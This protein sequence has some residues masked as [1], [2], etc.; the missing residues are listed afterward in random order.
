MGAAEGGDRG[1]GVVVD[2][3][4]VGVGCGART[5]GGGG[6]SGVDGVQHRVGEGVWSASSGGG[7]GG[8]FDGPVVRADAA[9]GVGVAGPDRTAHESRVRGGEIHAF[10]AASRF[11][12]R[13]WSEV[14]GGSERRVR[15]HG[16]K[17][18]DVGRRRWGHDDLRHGRIVEIG[19]LG[20]DL[21]PGRSSS[22]IAGAA[23]G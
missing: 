1:R 6:P 22:S 2:W 14:A 7:G 19:F 8:R 11:A 17:L 12:G 9:V 23:A 3:V 5:L 4:L 20:V 16:W 18:G 10:E 15:S 13:S 21:V